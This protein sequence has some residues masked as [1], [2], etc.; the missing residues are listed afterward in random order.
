MH[1]CPFCQAP[2]PPVPQAIEAGWCPSYYDGD[3]EVADP[4]CPACQES[5]LVLD[6][7][8]GEMMLPDPVR[9]E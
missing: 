3:D 1:R 9:S 4:V 8:T 2:M 5:R 6:D 7:L